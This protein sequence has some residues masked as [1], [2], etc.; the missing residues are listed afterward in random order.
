MSR[1]IRQQAEEAMILLAQGV[2]RDA[3]GAVDA[4]I[5]DKWRISQSEAERERLHI[6]QGAL[7]DIEAEL[8]EIIRQ[9]ADNDPDRRANK[10]SEFLK[11][12]YH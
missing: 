2:F 12:F 6:K 5:V 9:A 11:R 3:L 8:V 1:S 7:R 4:R 10:F